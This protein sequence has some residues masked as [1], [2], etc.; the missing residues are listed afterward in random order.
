MSSQVRKF[1]LL[2]LI[3]VFFYLIF[4]LAEIFAYLALSSNHLFLAIF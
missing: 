2:M 1:H 4:A 3:S